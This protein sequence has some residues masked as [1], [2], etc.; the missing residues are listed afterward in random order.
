MTRR[1]FAPLFTLVALGACATVPAADRQPVTV[2]ILAIN[3]FHGNL[4]TPLSPTHFADGDKLRQSRLGGA[5]QLAATVEHLRTG[6]SI[7]VA[8]GDLIGASPLVSSLFLDEPSIRVLSD[9]GLE[10]AAVGNHEFDRGIAELQR[11][12]NGGCDQYTRRTPCALEPFAGAG[13]TYLAANVVDEDGATLFPATAMRTIGDARIGFIGM[14][15]K[16]TAGLVANQATAGYEFHD[17]ATTANR[18]ARALRAAGADTVVVLIHEGANVDPRFNVAGC[19][20]LSGPIVP[21]AEALDPAISLVV[22]GHTHQAYSCKLATNAGAEVLLTSGGRYGGFVTDITMRIDPAANRV[23]SLE[24][25]NVAVD[26]SAGSVPAVASY[27]AR[28]AQASEGVANREIGPIAPPAGE[29][30]DCGDRIAQDLVADAYLFGAN[31]AL[32]DTVDLAFVNSG[33]VRAD[34]AGADDGVLTFGELSAMAPFG[35]SVIVLEMNGADIKALLEQQFCE[36]DP[37][38]VCNSLLIPSA[39]TTYTVDL[40]GPAGSRISALSI[41]GQPLDPARTYRVATNNFLAGG[42]DGFHTF[43]QVP[44]VANV[45]FDI[46]ALEAYVATGTIVVPICGRISHVSPVD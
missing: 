42:G 12:Q 10:L 11:M 27:V 6:N 5:A 41:N 33:G 25:R 21:I 29:G 2:Q 34:L 31:A 35:N 43:T 4:E 38:I 17:E 16:G 32:D 23:L 19:P 3:D 30:A 22:S 13:F 15:L 26:G 36:N 24:G 1:R 28:Y 20:G 45:G 44:Q 40:D 37:A 18:L 8:A 7:T 46:D 39:G 14:T 9:L